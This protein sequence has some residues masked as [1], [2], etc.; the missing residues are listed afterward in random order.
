M[1]TRLKSSISKKKA[2]LTST[3]PNYLDV[4]PPLFSV[5][6]A[7]TPWIDAMKDEFS[8]YTSRALGL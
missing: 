5:S 3:K 7:L 6:N 2:A 8:A 4:K 1:Q